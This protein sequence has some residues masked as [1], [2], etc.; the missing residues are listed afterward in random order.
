VCV[1]VCV[2]VFVCVCVSLYVCS[3]RVLSFSKSLTHT[4]WQTAWAAGEEQRKARFGE[5]IAAL[6]THFA[7]ACASIDRES[8]QQV[9]AIVKALGG[10]MPAAAGAS[11]PVGSEA[12][13]TAT[14][15]ARTSDASAAQPP[16][17]VDAAAAA[18]A[19]AP[20]PAPQV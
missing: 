16:A 7:S 3:F 12:T 5:Q 11:V 4:T 10:A 20:E 9:H 15:P 2:C 18:A 8:E 19:A 17:P 6:R 14:A 1:C 13:A